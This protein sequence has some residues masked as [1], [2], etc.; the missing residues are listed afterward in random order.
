MMIQ[1]VFRVLFFAVLTVYRAFAISSQSG[2][3][4]N[5]NGA[6]DG[7]AGLRTKDV[8]VEMVVSFVAPLGATSMTFSYGWKRQ[9]GN[10]IIYA[11]EVVLNNAAAPSREYGVF[12]EFG[13]VKCKGDCLKVSG[14]D[15]VMFRCVSE[16]GKEHCRV[17]NVRFY[18]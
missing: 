17:D 5:V 8:N 3:N 16:M 13:E 10:S 1:I 11:V 7:L 4:C 18:G 14:G 9:D 15:V 2:S 12:P 6:N